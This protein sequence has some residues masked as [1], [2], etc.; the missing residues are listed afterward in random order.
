[1]KTAISIP[2]P[3]FEAAERA[4]KQLNVSRSVLYARAVE[5]YVRD[6]ERKN[7]TARFNAALEDG[8]DGLDPAL[9]NMQ[10]A[11]LDEEW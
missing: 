4:A 5:E 2:D 6:L 3:L 7:L 11:R 8:D 9:A 10:Y 1:M